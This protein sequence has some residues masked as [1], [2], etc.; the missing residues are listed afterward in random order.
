MCRKITLK[1][2]RMEKMLWGK[3]EEGGFLFSPRLGKNRC[4][5]KKEWTQLEDHTLKQKSQS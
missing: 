3:E 2:A 5:S 1:F 4:C